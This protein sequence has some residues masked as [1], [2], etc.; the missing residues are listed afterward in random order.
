[1]KHFSVLRDL[2][3]ILQTCRIVLW[4]VGVR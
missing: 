1:M 2:S 4:P 3:I